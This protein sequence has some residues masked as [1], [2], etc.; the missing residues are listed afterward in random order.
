MA[1][2]KRPRDEDGWRMP[3]PGTISAQIYALAKQGLNSSQIAATLGRQRGT[4]SVHLFKIRNPERSN[5]I[6]TGW[7]KRLRDEGG[8]RVPRPDTISAQIYALAK[9]GLNSS[10]IAIELGRQR[11]TVSVHLFKIRNPERSNQIGT[12][13]RKRPRDEDGWRVPRPDTI[14]AQIYALAKQG[15]NSSQIAAALGRKRGTVSVHLFK[16]RNPERSYY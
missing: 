1:G 4:V 12:G 11:G 2:S 3:R 14:S 8:W 10:Q 7:R 16:I 15:L 5:Q 9:Q 6:G 13:W